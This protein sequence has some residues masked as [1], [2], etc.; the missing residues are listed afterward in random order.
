MCYLLPERDLTHRQQSMMGDGPSR[1]T[2]GEGRAETADER[3]SRVSS[4]RAGS[5]AAQGITRNTKEH[6]NQGGRKRIRRGGNWKSGTGWSMIAKQLQIPSLSA[7]A[8]GHRPQLSIYLELAAHPC[9]AR[10]DRE[11]GGSGGGSSSHGRPPRE[12]CRRR[13]KEGKEISGTN[14]DPSFICSSL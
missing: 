6:G 12:Q 14:T 2:G 10:R 7:A 4:A 5:L 1:R 11:R 13:S 9:A 3:R 8:D